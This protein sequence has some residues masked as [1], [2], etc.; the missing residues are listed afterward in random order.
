MAVFLSKQ[1]AFFISV[2]MNLNSILSL[3]CAVSSVWVALI[4][5]GE[6]LGGG[7]DLVAAEKNLAEETILQTKYIFRT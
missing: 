6:A 4:F 3:L 1:R 5:L 7:R 2:K